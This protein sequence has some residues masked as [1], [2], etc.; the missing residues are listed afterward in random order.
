MSLYQIYWQ[1]VVYTLL[2]FQNFLH[3]QDYSGESEIC[4][5]IDIIW[6]IFYRLEIDGVESHSSENEVNQP[7]IVVLS[8][9]SDFCIEVIDIDHVSQ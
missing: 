8:R 6:R 2:C 5:I 7:L 4:A 1:T 3:G 9:Y